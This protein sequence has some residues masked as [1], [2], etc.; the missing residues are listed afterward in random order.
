[1]SGIW[2]RKFY[3]PN[4]LVQRKKIIDALEQNGS[5]IERFRKPER[6]DV[7]EA[8]LSWFKHREVTRYQEAILF[9]PSFLFYRDIKFKFMYFL[10]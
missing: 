8:L 7:N 1:V 9:L 2:S 4:D 5:R 3:R 6:S 10:G